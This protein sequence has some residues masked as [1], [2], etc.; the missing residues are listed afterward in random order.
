MTKLNLYEAS[1]I[2]GGLP[3][4]NLLVLHRTLATVGNREVRVM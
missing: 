3:A 4:G 2:S 1:K